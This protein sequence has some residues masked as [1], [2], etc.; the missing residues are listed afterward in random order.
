MRTKTAFQMKLKAFFINFKSHSVKQKN[1]SSF[2][3]GESTTLVLSLSINILFITINESTN[4]VL[5]AITKD[6]LESSQTI[7]R[8]YRT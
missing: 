3:L 5:T 4:K 7:E 8:G 1:T 2:L 6:I